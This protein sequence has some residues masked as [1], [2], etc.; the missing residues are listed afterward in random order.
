MLINE[1]ESSRRCLLYFSYLFYWVG[2]YFGVLLSVNS[3]RSWAFEI[4]AY[5]F[6]HSV[7]INP[8]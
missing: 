6:S 7:G 2:S 4:H 5:C 3:S 1:L 8:T